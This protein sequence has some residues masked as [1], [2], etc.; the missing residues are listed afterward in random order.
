M[1][2]PD[3]YRGLTGVGWPRPFVRSHRHRCLL[4][5]AWAVAVPDFGEINEARRTTAPIIC[6]VCGES[7]RP[8][9]RVVIFLTTGLR[10]AEGRRLD[11]RPETFDRR[12]VVLEALDDA[13][14]HERCAALTAL[15][16]PHIRRDR[17]D[18]SFFAFIGPHD[19]IHDMS[20]GTRRFLAMLGS[21]AMPWKPPCRSSSDPSTVHRAGHGLD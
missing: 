20:D 14:M 8:Q 7:H 13:V 5:V 11:A 19:S 2:L 6:Q 17:A 9:D 1:R 15:H 16:C 4:P 21:A 3:D 18:H 10:D 12:N